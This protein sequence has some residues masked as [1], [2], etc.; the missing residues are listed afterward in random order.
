MVGGKLTNFKRGVVHLGFY[1]N[2]ELTLKQAREYNFNDGGERG[3]CD[4]FSHSEKLELHLELL[5]LHAK[6]LE[7]TYWDN[8]LQATRT[9]NDITAQKGVVII[10]GTVLRN[11]VDAAADYYG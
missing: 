4:D 6:P 1:V 10:S 2:F 8:V 11:Q 7:G 3:D 5:C 9:L